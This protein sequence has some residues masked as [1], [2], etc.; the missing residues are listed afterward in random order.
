MAVQYNPGIVTNGLVLCLDAA[1]T[2]SYPRTGTGWFDLS[3]SNVIG[4]FVNG[5]TFNS[6]NQGNIVFDGTD[7]V[8]NTTYVSSSVFTWS[9][10]FKTDVVSSGYRNIIS[11]PSPNYMLML[12]DT[13]TANLGFWTPDGLGGVNLST[14]TIATNT[15]YNAV[16][17]REG[18]SITGGYKA[19]VNAVLYGN[20]NTGTWSS[21]STLSLGGRTNESQFL[22]GNIAQAS[23]YN[24]ALTI[25]EIQQNFNALRGRFGI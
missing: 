2:K 25:T 23:I 11:I 18:N 6:S 10:W 7:D 9:A 17:V 16:F 22:D 5:A 13:S 3:G 19:Y 15:W 12:L 21:S 1:N 4:T 24:R 20:A 14:P 8:I